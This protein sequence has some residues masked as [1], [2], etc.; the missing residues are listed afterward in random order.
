MNKIISRLRRINYEGAAMLVALG[1]W[2][3]LIINMLIWQ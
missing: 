3:T 2:L 1:L